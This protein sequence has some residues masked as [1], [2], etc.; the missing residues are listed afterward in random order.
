MNLKSTRMKTYCILFITLFT[1]KAVFSAPVVPDNKEISTE[2]KIL[3]ATLFFSGVQLQNE[4]SAGITATGKTLVKIKNISSYADEKSVQ[5]SGEGKFTILSVNYKSSTGKPEDTE[6]YK[7]MEKESKAIEDKIKEEKTWIQILHQRESFYDANVSVTGKSQ[8]ISIEQ[9]KALGDMYAKNIETIKFAITEKAKKIDDLEEEL[10]KANEKLNDFKNAQ[11]TSGGE[12][13]VLLSTTAPLTAKFHISYFTYNAG[14]YP[15]YDIRVNKLNE[16]M[17]FIYKA[18]IYQNSGLDWKN[19]SIKCSNATP[20]Q[21]GDMPQLNPYYLNYGSSY[22]P[23]AAVTAVKQVSGMV[24]DERTSEALP[25]ATV[26]VKGTNFGTVTGSDGQFRLNVPAGE[27][28]LEFHYVGYVSTDRNVMDS[29]MDITLQPLR[30]DVDKEVLYPDIT[31]AGNTHEVTRLIKQVPG[32]TD[33]KK[34]FFSG[35]RKSSGYTNPRFLDDGESDIPEVATQVA[36]TSIDFEIK[37]PYTVK[38]DGAIMTVDIKEGEVVASFEYHTTPKLEASAFLIARIPDWEKYNLLEGDAN[39]Y[40]ENTFVGKSTLD[41][42]QMKDTLSISLGRDKNVVIK[43]EKIKETTQKQLL[44]SNRIVTRSWK[45]S[46]RSNKNTAIQL[47]IHD[48]LPVSEN[49]DIT[50]EKIDISGAKENTEKGN[51]EW[52]L[53][54]QP[55]E[56]KE[57]SLKYSV[58]YPK[59]SVIEVY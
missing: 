13:W 51:L 46:A 47:Y 52:K 25:G 53:E 8:V 43:R 23:T 24:R 58:K 39:L 2:A 7:K 17:S 18:N 3:S 31:V 28:K 9:L 27:S 49:K 54:L 44:G 32:V 15:S 30:V 48:Q 45:I 50:V 34:M 11:L 37:E 21:Q 6:A 55:N 36:A 16:P 56:T 14:W 4:C 57:V 38:S 29:Y 10:K 5:V 22:E 26:L 42:S 40:I 1:A 59:N 20:F 12:I 41:I 35:K 19:I 33:S